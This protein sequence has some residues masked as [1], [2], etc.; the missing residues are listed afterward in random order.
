MIPTTVA[1]TVATVRASSSQEMP[2]A[3]MHSPK[4]PNAGTSSNDHQRWP[5]VGGVNTG[6]AGCGRT[7][8]ARKRIVHPSPLRSNPML[9]PRGSSVYERMGTTASIAD[10]ITLRAVLLATV[11]RGATR[12]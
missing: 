1:V 10:A 7:L 2:H 3:R 5:T 6:G 4:K 8:G 9:E 12:I 11:H